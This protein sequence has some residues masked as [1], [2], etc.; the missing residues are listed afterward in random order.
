M[1]EPV[2]ITDLARTM[3]ALSGMTEKT[4]DEPHGDIEISFVG[5]R[6]GEKLHEELFIGEAVTETV[7]PQIK[8]AM[9]R[10]LPLRE[11]QP[12]LKKLEA[13][14][15]AHDAQGVR[16]VLADLLELDF[17]GGSTESSEAA[18]THYASSVSIS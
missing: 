5:L 10:F 2:R 18:P 13:V 7:H 9:E 8:M 1:G 16:A 14:L 11:L 15:E 6:P 12:K 17:G 3:I 4:R